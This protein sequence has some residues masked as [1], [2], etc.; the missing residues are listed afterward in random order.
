MSKVK[1]IDKLLRARRKL[2]HIVTESY[3]MTWFDDNYYKIQKELRKEI[4][5][6]KGKNELKQA[7]YSAKQWSNRL[8]R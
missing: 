7:R 4:C 3:I 1:R 6:I 8:T 5:R 2:E